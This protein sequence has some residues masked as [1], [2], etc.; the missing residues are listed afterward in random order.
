MLKI[1]LTMT[2]KN[3]LTLSSLALIIGSLLI[4]LGIGLFFNKAL[5]GSSI[6]LGFGLLLLSLSIL[7]V[8]KRMDIYNKTEI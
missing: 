7:K 6:G 4:G 5:V 2:K 1:K 8:I 3:L